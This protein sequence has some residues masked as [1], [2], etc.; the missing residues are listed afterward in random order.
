VGS[1]PPGIRVSYAGATETGARVSDEIE[2]ISDGEGLAIVGDGKAVHRFLRERGLLARAENLE[3]DRLGSLVQAS[4]AVAE[5]VSEIATSSGM[6]LKLTDESAR[7]VQEFGLME[8]NVPGVRHVMIG[9]P[10]AINKW[11]QAESDV[12]A[13]L[14][15]PALFAGAA[16]V[17]AQLARQHEMR[18]IAAYLARIDG[19]LDDVRRG[20]RDAILSRIDGAD[21]QLREALTVRE[22]VG[23]VSDVTWSTVQATSGIVA[24]VQAAAL[25]E[26]SGLAAK[27]E[28]ASNVSDLI[29]ATKE[30]EKEAAVWLAVL[31]K[32][33]EMQDAVAILQLDRV[34]DTSADELGKNRAGLAAAKAERRGLI[35]R[36][37]ARLLE[38]LDAAAGRANLNILLHV[39]AARAIV[40]A[41]N[42]ASSDVDEFHEP[43]GIDPNRESAEAIRWR[44]AIRDRAQWGKA[45][46]EAGPK[47]GAAVVV[48]GVAAFMVLP[49]TR[50][51]ASKALQA[52]LTTL[53]S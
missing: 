7:L 38:Q 8:T 13:L 51:L 15:N 25:R 2:L 18:Q 19:K 29:S 10:G 4:G 6:W 17:M 44:D 42:Q 47:V 43:L 3:L 45:V 21:L 27:L 26:L 40:G 23:R 22:H 50:P 53:R 24:E 39:P 31:A 11:L 48:A 20:Q 49:Q 41:V 52:A 30:V 9:D 37:T 5:G 34:L 36:H 1:T 16:G 32:C 46:K 35:V 28:R 12:G 33:F 14:A